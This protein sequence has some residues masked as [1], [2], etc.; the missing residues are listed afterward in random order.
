[1]KSILAL[2][3]FNCKKVL[4]QIIPSRKMLLAG[5]FLFSMTLIC[6]TGFSFTNDLRSNGYSLIPAPQQIEISGTNIIVDQSWKVNVGTGGTKVSY[7]GLV[8]GAESLLNLSFDGSG[9]KEIVLTVSDGLLDKFVADKELA[10]QGYKLTITAD[11]VEVTGNSEMGLYYGVQ[12][13]LQLLRPLKNGKFSLPEG[14]ITD[15]P[16][17]QL[18][19]A[20]WDTKHHQDRIETLKRYLDQS[21][22]FKINAIT[23]E[24]EDKYEYPSHPIIGAPGAFTKAEMQELS[25][26]ALERYI[27]LIPVIQ[28]PSHM[29]YVL[30]H[31]EF[32]HLRA[33]GMNYQACLCDDESIELIF[34]MYQDMIDATPGMDYF[35]VSTDELYYAGTCGKC[36][37][38]YNDV[39]RSQAWVDFANKAYDWL[40]KR[41]RI[42][43][44]WI[45][46]PLLQSDLKKLPS[47]LIGP[48][49]D[50][51]PKDWI[52]DMKKAGIKQ[53]AYSSMQGNEM[54]FPNYYPTFFRGRDIKGRLEDAS[55][56]VPKTLKNDADLIGTFAAAW[57]DAGLHNET[58]WLGWATVNQY[59]WSI[60]QPVLEQSTADFM[61]AFYGYDSPDLVEAYVLLEEGAR[62]YEDLWD[63]VISKER[64]P[65]YGS[66][67]GKGIGVDR[68]DLTLAP[69]PLPSKGDIVM[70]P[71]FRE[72]YAD[73][74][75]EASRLIKN[76]DRLI[77]ILQDALTS[78][79]RNRY[80]IEVLLSLAYLE[81]HTINTVLN[82]AKVEDQLLVAASA[83]L[84]F[85]RGVSQLFEAY[86]MVDEMIE[87]EKA[88]WENF[89]AVWEKSQFPKCRSVDGRDFVHVFD[90]VKDHFADRRLGLEYM[91]APFER[92]DLAGWQKQLS[93]IIQ[94]YAKAKNVPIKANEIE[95]LEH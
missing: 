23:F 54:L 9:S 92:M 15:W 89:V 22:Y 72:R 40:K 7:S 2:E 63:N 18:R 6:R 55:K 44:S 38:E 1:M 21:A 66:S 33:D 28:A 4:K 11:R 65:G 95:R 12:S 78:V 46:Y 85:A 42:M 20:H 56:T 50:E 75:E 13:L 81:R 70:V 26:Y 60:G 91:M 59:A 16:D 36:K 53:F 35:Y 8:K 83:R 43:L 68:F 80:N 69:P 10:K 86:K 34:D 19:M 14:N 82:L 17:L 27:Q 71:E 52:D 84:D 47:G 32:A 5:V 87:E 76:N 57:G 93:S 41:D 58:F 31:E 88:M 79:E 67:R 61:D 62:Y 77:A 25:A 51:E 39:N 37:K 48:I 30:K 90:D 49:R 3:N 73:K 45:E 64:G 94:S 74:I 24:I 29:A